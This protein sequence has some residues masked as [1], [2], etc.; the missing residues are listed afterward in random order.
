MSRKPT[1]ASPSSS[2]VADH[3]GPLRRSVAQKNPK[4]DG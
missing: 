1:A 3:H 2:I 4:M